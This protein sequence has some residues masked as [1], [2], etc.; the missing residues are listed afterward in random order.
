MPNVLVGRVT[1]QK[2]VELGRVMKFIKD[3]IVLEYGSMAQFGELLKSIRGDIRQSFVDKYVDRKYSVLV[4]TK[5][6]VV[7]N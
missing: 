3:V 1:G 7:E 5:V 2:T 6:Q 4:A